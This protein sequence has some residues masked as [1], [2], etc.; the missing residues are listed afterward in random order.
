MPVAR[1]SHLFGVF[2]TVLLALGAFSV[3]A[4]QVDPAI[5]SPAAQAGSALT[6][7]GT[8][9]ELIV[10]D[11]V[12]GVTQRYLG[13]QLD[14]GQSVVL[15]GA[16]VEQL[17]GGARIEV[18]GYL[19]GNTLQVTGF[20]VLAAA[21]VAEKNAAPASSTQQ[22]QGTLVIFHKDYF[23]EGRGEYHFGVHAVHNGATQM[24]PL[25]VAVMP[26][27]L[28]PG[29]TVMATGTTAADGAS[30]DATQVT[31]LAE[32]PAQNQPLGVTTTN[33]VLVLPIKFADSPAGDPFTT[34][35]ID[36]V[37]RTNANS[38]AAY[39]NE[40]SYGAQQLNITV[41]HS[42]SGGWLVS[43]SNTPGSCDFTTIGNLG[44][45]AAAAAGYNISSYN[46]R[47]YVI[48]SNGACGW[49]GLA[50]IGPPY[51][52]WS[53][54]YNALWVYGHE[55]GHNFLLYHAGSVNCAPQV[56][57]GSCSVNEYGDR[58]DVM[59]NNST[60]GEQMHFD[61]AQKA[62]LGWIPPSSVITQTSGT[63]TY[64][65][66]PLESGGQSTYAITI[67]VPA[68]STRTY[69]IEYRQPIG[70]DAGIANYP[71]LGAIIH[72]SS[73]FDYP[74]SGCGGDDTE[75]L[76]PG[77]TGNFYDAALLVGQ[78]YTDSTYGIRI[79]V[80]S[81]TASA[82][83]VTVAMGGTSA[84]TTTLAS[85][86]NP[87][88]SGASVTF[89]AT[90]TGS[91]PTGSVGFTAD[92][93]TLAGCSAVAL[94]TGSANSKTATCSTAGLAVG[95]HS[96]VATYGGDANNSGSSATLS[97]VVNS[98]KTTSTT[99]LV[100]SANP[101]LSGASVTFTATVAGSAPTG[102]VGFTADGSTLSGCSAVALATGSANS[103]TATCSTAGLAVGTHSIV[104][105]YGGDAN[106]R[107][108]QRHPLAGRQQ[109]SQQHRSRNL[110]DALRRGCKRHLH[111]DGD[112]QRADRH[113]G[114]HRRWQRD[115]RLCCGGAR[116]QRQDRDLQHGG[117][118]RRHAQHRGHLR[119]GCQQH[120]LDQPDLVAGG[121]YRRQHNHAGE[122]SQSVA[123]RQ[124][125]DLHRHGRRVQSHRQR[126][127]H[128][129][130]EARLPAV[131]RW[132]WRAARRLVR[133]R[134]SRLR[135]T[136][137]SP[138]TAATPTTRPRPAHRSR[139]WST[140]SRAQPRSRARSIH[141]W[142]GRA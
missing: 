57:G 5:A 11:Q 107:L 46:N 21:H 38:T 103:K 104:A 82:L 89:T 14:N 13:L 40:V 127:L 115:Q 49:A 70:F 135:P 17:A 79:T 18:T 67:P 15:T 20:N 9:A 78:T 95:T 132:R 72:V 37:M 16:G 62:I 75:I 129:R 122:L 136:P 6:G 12:A 130:R 28:H 87:S 44:D 71:N 101:S 56:L 41:A 22:V 26:E 25:N 139:R 42:S 94:A 80:N 48:P 86:A 32:A 54:G 142:L 102:S 35:Q 109:S 90:V 99:T 2:A 27:R 138:I 105:T 126:Q 3:R 76:D 110:R 45:Q 141:P 119:W 66:S 125:R 92:G 124:Q 73:P 116:R 58:F 60:P 65:L 59:S 23:A 30:L 43:S 134:A 34:A 31:V 108:D 85:S 98:D 47:F 84:S 128:R 24:T 96:I 133:R 68:D 55:L 61:A 88:L 120:R 83:S 64:T 93:S 118:C 91:A 117:S 114:L 39:Y 4:H 140:R 121:Q 29:M 97:Q 51:Q 81:A 1:R 113:R 77:A 52:A 111:C 106:N 10:V 112:R 137:S 19:G 53:N 36:Q 74:C 123:V 50:Y 33:Q 100:S 131:P 8:V 69:W 7:T 63:A